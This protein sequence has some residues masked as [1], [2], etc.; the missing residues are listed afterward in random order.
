MEKSP[1]LEQTNK[2]SLTIYATTPG[3]GLDLQP[4]SFKAGIKVS[5]WF[6]KQGKGKYWI[7]DYDLAS[8]H[9]AIEIV[10]ILSGDNQKGKISCLGGQGMVSRKSWQL[11]DVVGLNEV[12]KSVWEL[13]MDA[14]KTR[15]DAV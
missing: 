11:N 10:D 6:A 7:Y 8:L 12:G 4:P 15:L 2:N 9:H 13:D 14:L 5:D 3:L 1:T